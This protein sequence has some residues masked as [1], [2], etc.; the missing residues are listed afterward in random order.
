MWAR[1]KKSCTTIFFIYTSAGVYVCMENTVQWLEVQ[2]GS[3]Q[4][5]GVKKHTHIIMYVVIY[6][7]ISTYI[8]VASYS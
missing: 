3:G 1:S 4:W 6:V 7:H 5:K 8:Y 2:H